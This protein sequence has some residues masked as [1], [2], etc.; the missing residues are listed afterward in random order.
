MVM[1]AMAGLSVSPMD[2][3]AV[4]VSVSSAVESSM[5]GTLT[6]SSVCPGASAST[7]GV[8]TKSLPAVDKINQ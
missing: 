6:L 2:N 7:L 8:A 5:M 3:M 4:N 1:V